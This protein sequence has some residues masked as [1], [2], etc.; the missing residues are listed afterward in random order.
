MDPASSLLGR[1]GCAV[2]LDCAQGEWRH[3]RLPARIAI[4]V[5]DSGTRHSLAESGY[6]DR[7]A[8]LER[9]LPALAGRRP[10]ELTLPEALS[11]ARAAGVD[12]L[13]IR[14]LRHV[15]TENARVRDFV[16]RIEAPTPA[17]GALGS[18]ML[19]S[20]ESLRDDFEVSTPELDTLVELAYAH[21]AIGARLTG[22]GFGGSVVAL[23]EREA[24]PNV[25][26]EVAAA[27]RERT[28]RQG[29]AWV[30][31]AVDGAGDL[32]DAQC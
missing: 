13:A 16:E 25:A 32:E 8:E 22:G 15:V 17:L 5:L 27:F 14:R 31:A 28:G 26:R 3:V 11:L 4:V 7:R 20:H 29:N 10:A 23:A 30:C 21:G 24:A 12:E 19:A 2:L 9:A 6:R 1:R 18:I